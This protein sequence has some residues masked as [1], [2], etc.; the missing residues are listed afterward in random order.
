MKRYGKILL[1]II[2]ALY[3]LLGYYFNGLIGILSLR[4]VDP[5]YI[6]LANGLYMSTGDLNV[7]HIDNP[8]TPLQVIVALVCRLVYL[9]RPNSVPY[10]EDVLINSDLYLN[11]INHTLISLTAILLYVAGSILTKLTSFLPFGLLLQTAPFFTQITYDIAGRVVPEL[12]ITLPVLFLSIMLIK[13]AKENEKK[14]DNKKLLLYGVISGVGLSV[15]LT[16][17]PLLLIPLLVIPGIR[18]KLKFLLYSLISLFIFAFPILFDLVAFTKWMFALLLGSGQYGGGEQNVIDPGT[19]AHNFWFFF[20]N[21]VFLV[22]IWLLSIAS[23][24]AYLIIKRKNINHRLVYGLSGI[25]VTLLIQVLIVS[26]H[27]EYRYLVPGLALFPAMVI[28]SFEILRDFISFKRVNL[29]IAAIIIA[30]SM[31]MIPQHMKR[32]REVSGRISHEMENKLITKHFVEM[33]EKDAVKLITPAPYGCPFH[34]FSI[35]ISSCWAGKANRLFLPVYK[36]LYPSSYFYFKWEGQ[37][38]YWE[39]EYDVSKIIGS[40]KPVYFYISENNPMLY[41]QSLSAM[42][43][44]YNIDKIDFE[45]IFENEAT[46]ERIFELSFLIE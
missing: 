5:E 31:I 3:L 28:L 11:I 34:D 25:L 8:G 15:K 6:Y 35:M 41:E 14:F 21:H 22:I 24:L 2:P 16:F 10:I 29:I 20:N 44:G 39:E 32:V 42:L 27:Y 37:T 30:G 36:K 4:N 45:V 33:L 13:A 7:S 12:L 19:F 43:H 9:F 46:N 40:K 18:D 38:K 23:L 26:K 17:M 1:V